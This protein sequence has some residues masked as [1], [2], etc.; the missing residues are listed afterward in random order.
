VN[1]CRRDPEF[2]APAS[3]REAI[4]NEKAVASYRTPQD[5]ARH[6]CVP[7]PDLWVK[8]SR[9]T[10]TR[11]AKSASCAF[12]GKCLDGVIDRARALQLALHD[13]DLADAKWL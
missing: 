9:P 1:C 4:W 5:R 7:Q 8:I 3:W 2:T 13:D 12:Q 11:G 10:N 6:P